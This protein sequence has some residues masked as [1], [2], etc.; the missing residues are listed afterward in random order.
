MREHAEVSN[1]VLSLNFL[2]EAGGSTGELSTINQNG[3]YAYTVLTLQVSGSCHCFAHEYG[4][5]KHLKGNKSLIRWKTK[6]NKSIFKKSQPVRILP[7][8]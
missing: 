1:L 3:K 6:V 2:P 7:P 5:C 8:G 4:K